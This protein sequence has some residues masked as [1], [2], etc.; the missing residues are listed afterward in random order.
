MRKMLI[1]I[2]LFFTFSA[3]TV[4]PHQAGPPGQKQSIEDFKERYFGKNVS[5]FRNNV[6]VSISYYDVLTEIDRNSL[7]DVSKILLNDI[8][9]ILNS[10]EDEFLRSKYVNDFPK[11]F[12]EFCRIFNP[13]DS[14][15]LYDGSYVFLEMFDDILK[16]HPRDTVGVLLGLSVNATYDAD[17]PGNLQH[18]LASFICSNYDFFISPFSQLARSGQQNIITFVCDVENF[19]AYAEFDCII[20]VL[21]EKGN[22]ELARRF[23]TA[24]EERIS[25]GP[26]GE[27]VRKK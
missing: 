15:E 24:K 3:Q 10:P 25:I 1:L 27:R 18:I 6:Q 23:L 26:H 19:S 20:R 11:T 5:A 12:A 8:L 16:G 13:S 9:A 14:K 4:L 21:K 22:S 17:A 2:F 7:D